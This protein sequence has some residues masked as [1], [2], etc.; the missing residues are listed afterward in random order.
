M[1]QCGTCGDKLPEIGEHVCWVKR[2]MREPSLPMTCPKCGR[3][4]RFQTC[5]MP[6]CVNSAG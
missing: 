4:M 5:W 3:E 1:S 2:K 6:A